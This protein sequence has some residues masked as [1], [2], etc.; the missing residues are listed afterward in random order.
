LS[1]DEIKRI[2]KSGFEIGF[3]TLRHHNLQTLSVSQLEEALTDGLDDIEDLT[4]QRPTSI[5]YPH[6]RADRRI[7]DAARK[8]GFELGLI[9][10]GRAVKAEDDPLLMDRVDGWSMSIGQFT[11]RLTRAVRAATN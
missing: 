9:C 1:P 6:C 3:H 5:A 4:R 7:A 10:G 11:L 2:A 8:A